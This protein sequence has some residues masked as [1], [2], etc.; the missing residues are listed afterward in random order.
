MN[1]EAIIGY[2]EAAFLSVGLLAI[3]LLM[4]RVFHPANRQTMKD[5]A[6]SIFRGEDAPEPLEPGRDAARQDH[7]G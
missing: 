7:N 4:V 3:F 1:A 5:H 6:N 2:S